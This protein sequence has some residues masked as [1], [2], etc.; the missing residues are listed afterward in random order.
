MCGGLLRA[1]QHGAHHTRLSAPPLLRSYAASTSGD[2]GAAVLCPVCRRAP[3][4]QLHGVIGC[5]HEQWQLP[6]AG[7][8]LT[9]DHVRRRLAQIYE[10]GRLSVAGG[11]AS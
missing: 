4:V 7:E 1:A 6:V 10:V 3:L 8:G 5:P 2:A 11:I 9:L